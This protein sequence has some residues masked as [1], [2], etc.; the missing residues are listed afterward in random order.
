MPKKK[1]YY[2][3]KYDGREISGVLSEE[4]K[5]EAFQIMNRLFDEGHLNYDPDEVEVVEMWEAGEG[6]P[7]ME[8]T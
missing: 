8:G 5:F 2:K 6:R 1:R 3:L 4:G 7:D